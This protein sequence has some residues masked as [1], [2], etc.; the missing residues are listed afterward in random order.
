MLPLTRSQLSD[1]VKNLESEVELLEQNLG[2]SQSALTAKQ[3]EAANASQELASTREQLEEATAELASCNETLVET[4]E[5]LKEATDKLSTF[6]SEVETVAKAK[7]NAY[8]EK[9]GHPPLNLEQSKDDPTEPAEKS[10][11]EQFEDITDPKES[12]Q[13]AKEHAAEIEA[14]MFAN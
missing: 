7:A 4:Q 3:E 9:L 5:A 11:L 14:A 13:F 2:E 12:F 8:L 10:I 6:D 1:K